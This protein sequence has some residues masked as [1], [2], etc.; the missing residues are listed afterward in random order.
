MTINLRE[1][2]TE[3]PWPKSLLGEE[4]MRML[5]AGRAA[6]RARGP[7][8][9]PLFGD[10]LPPTPETDDDLVPYPYPEVDQRT[11]FFIP[12]T[13]IVCK[14][15]ETRVVCEGI[16][17]CEDDQIR[18]DAVDQENYHWLWVEVNVL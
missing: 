4:V 14:L 15:G 16:Y 6:A 8:P 7:M 13:A 1:I 12:A 9:P 18:I 5:T 2:P 11:N 10:I 3:G 17:R